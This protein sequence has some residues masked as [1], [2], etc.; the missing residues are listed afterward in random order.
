VAELVSLEQLGAQQAS[1]AAKV[2]VQEHTDSARF[3]AGVHT[4]KKPGEEAASGHYSATAF[5][6]PE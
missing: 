3:Q 6:S 5:A 1:Q 2:S 4:A